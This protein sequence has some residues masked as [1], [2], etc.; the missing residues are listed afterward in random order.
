MSYKNGRTPQ[1]GDPVIWR[2]TAGHPVV[3]VVVSLGTSLQIAV[4]NTF[5]PPPNTLNTSLSPASVLTADKDGKVRT[6]APSLASYVNTSECL[7][8]DDVLKAFE[9]DE[10]KIP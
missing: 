4:H 6:F 10:A 7:H 1:I 3:G 2:D 5:T 8:A 9:A